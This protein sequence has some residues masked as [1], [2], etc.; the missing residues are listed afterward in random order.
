MPISV[1]IRLVDADGSILLEHARTLF[2]RYADELC[3]AEVADASYPKG[4]S[5][6]EPSSRTRPC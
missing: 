3:V 5:P 1:G 4:K 2:R 6:A